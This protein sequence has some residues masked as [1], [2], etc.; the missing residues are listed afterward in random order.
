MAP[1]SKLGILMRTRRVSSHL[2]MTRSP[3]VRVFEI[4]VFLLQ[5]ARSSSADE[6]TVCIIDTFRS[7]GLPR[8]EGEEMVGCEP[9]VWGKKEVASERIGPDQGKQKRTT[10]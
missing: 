8:K 7:C 3:T 6:A 10:V 5:K 9:V 4:A 1:E 2:W